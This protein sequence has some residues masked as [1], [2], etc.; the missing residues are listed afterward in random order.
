MPDHR[1]PV[2]LLLDMGRLP[3]VDYLPVP[4]PAADTEAADLLQQAE[5][6]F[7]EL[8][9]TERQSLCDW[10]AAS[11]DNRLGPAPTC[12]WAFIWWETGG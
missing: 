3:R 9:A 6:L 12:R 7:G 2:N 8:T 11:P 10:H 1:Y 5:A 4:A